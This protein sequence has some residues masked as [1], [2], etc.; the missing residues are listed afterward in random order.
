M[1]FTRLPSGVAVDSTHGLEKSG[2]GG[3]TELPQRVQQFGICA[4]QLFVKQQFKAL[5]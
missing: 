5:I 4:Q 1:G 2:E 3:T